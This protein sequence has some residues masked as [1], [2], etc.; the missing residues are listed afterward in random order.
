M[1]LLVGCQPFLHFHLLILCFHILFSVFRLCG[2]FIRLIPTAQTQIG[3]FFLFSIG[4][5][6]AP[7]SLTRIPSSVLLP[8]SVASHLP[9]EKTRASLQ[10]LRA[11]L[12]FLWE[13]FPSISMGSNPT[14]PAGLAASAVDYTSSLPSFLPTGC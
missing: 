2:L 3:H 4:A 5:V 11:V 10:M 7:P 6:G 9:Y 12:P 8:E 1:G 13:S 14:T